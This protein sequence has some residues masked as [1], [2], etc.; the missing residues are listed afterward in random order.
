MFQASIP[1]TKVDLF[2]ALCFEHEINPACTRVLNAHG[3][4]LQERVMIL[5][6]HFFLG[7]CEFRSLKK[8]SDKNMKDPPPPPP[9]RSPSEYSVIAL[10][11]S[12]TLQ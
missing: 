11:L 8:W 3:V 12:C 10:V 5:A 2:E 1:G 6:A 4:F 7:L 9:A